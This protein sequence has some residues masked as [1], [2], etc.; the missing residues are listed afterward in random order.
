MSIPSELSQEA[1]PINF[2]AQRKNQMLQNFFEHG[3]HDHESYA[4]PLRHTGSALLLL[5]V[6]I[7]NNFNE[8]S[9]RYF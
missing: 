7:L 5:N 3:P 2:F 6:P 4:L 8:I 9:H 1:V